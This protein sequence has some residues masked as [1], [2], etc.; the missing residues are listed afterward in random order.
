MQNV[1]SKDECLKLIGNIIKADHKKLVSVFQAELVDKSQM[2][3]TEIHDLLSGKKDLDSYPV[4]ILVWIYGALKKYNDDIPKVDYFFTDKEI[5][6]SEVFQISRVKAQYPLQFEILRKPDPYH[7]DYLMSI[8]IKTLVTLLE[9]GIIQL[10]PEMQRESEISSYNGILVSN[11]KFNPDAAREISENMSKNTYRTD[12]IRLI[13]VTDGEEDY[14][15]SSGK[16]IVNSGNIALIDGNHRL[17]AS[18]M[19]VA[20][21][22]NVDLELVVMFTVGTLKDGKYIIAQSEK[23]QPL[24]SERLKAFESTP[25]SSIVKGFATSLDLDRVYKFCQTKEEFEK[26]VG[27]VLE[28]ILID[29]V[30][31]FYDMKSISKKKENSI[32]TWLVEFFNELAD[33]LNDDFANYRAIKKSRWSATPYAFAGYIYLS[34][35]LQDISDWQIKLQQIIKG[36]DFNK[37]PWRVNARNQDKVAV[38][39]FEEVISHVLG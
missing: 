10:D 1:N 3:M 16:L 28:S 34:S 29:S 35:K 22:G 27:F 9:N 20:K 7:E 19:A 26:G 39:V 21:Y 33:I 14:K 5:K 32:K 12:M 4:E 31:K 2:T 25:E 37:I 36:I 30:K 23:R 38:Q 6:A 15:V 18:E 11:I 8:P 24:N 13:L 17:R